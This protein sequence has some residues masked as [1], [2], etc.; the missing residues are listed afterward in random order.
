M[1]FSG[2]SFIAA[3]LV[4]AAHGTIA[5]SLHIHAHIRREDYI[6]GTGYN[7]Q[8]AQTINV[9]LNRNATSEQIWKAPSNI[10]PNILVPRTSLVASAFSFGGGP[11]GTIDGGPFTGRTAGGGTRNEIYGTARYGSGHGSYNS[12][13]DGI[14]QYYP[15]L[16]LNVSG[17]DFPHGFPPL[18]FGNYSGGSYYY[19]VDKSEFAGVHDSPNFVDGSNGQ[20]IGRIWSLELPVSNRT[21]VIISDLATLETINAVIALPIPQGGCNLFGQLPLPTKAKTASVWYND[22][23][24]PDGDTVGYSPYTLPNNARRKPYYIYPWNVLQFYRGSSVALAS[25]EYNNAFARNGNNNTDY[26]ASTLLNTTDV[27]TN[28]LDCLNHTIAATIPIVDPTLIV[29]S[30]LSG[31]QVAG[32]AVG[33]FVAINLILVGACCFF[34]KKRNRTQEKKTSPTHPTPSGEQDRNKKKVQQNKPS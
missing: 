25:V 33:S 28:F 20:S 15:I 26:W 12:S 18:S 29:H 30:R 31:S 7:T 4:Q 6:D 5:T 17:R 11:K 32:I 23:T 19:D 3:C 24:I 27:D 9:P 22:T 34:C 8:N 21:W 16:N 13:I 14:T 2:H 1:R 10:D